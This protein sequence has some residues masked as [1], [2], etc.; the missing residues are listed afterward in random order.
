MTKREK[1]EKYF[2]MQ[3][4]DVVTMCSECNFSFTVGVG[5]QFEGRNLVPVEKMNISSKGLAAL[6][7]ILE[8]ELG[9]IAEHN[10]SFS[11]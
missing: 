7:E 4:A 8:T 11:F 1:C 10:K 6:G 5:Y 2:W 9:C 3:G